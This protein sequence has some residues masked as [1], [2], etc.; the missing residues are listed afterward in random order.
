MRSSITHLA[1]KEIECLDRQIAAVLENKGFIIQ[2]CEITVRHGGRLQLYVSYAAEGTNLSAYFFV[3]GDM[4]ELAEF[5]DKVRDK[6]RPIKS[7]EQA[8]V[9][10]AT[11]KVAAA[12]EAVKDLDDSVNFDMSNVRSDLY[13]T[14]TALNGR[15]LTYEGSTDDDDTLNF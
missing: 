12:I 5:M 7:V 6:L 8:Q 9:K 14:L 1:L 13:Q 2:A 4:N 11:E 10:D 15:L 3:Y